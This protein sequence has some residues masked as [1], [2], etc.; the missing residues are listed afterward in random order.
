MFRVEERRKEERGPQ[1]L[2]GFDPED[3]AVIALD[4]DS[5]AV[6]SEVRGHLDTD[7][8]G[9]LLLSLVMAHPLENLTY[10]HTDRE[11]EQ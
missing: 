3:L 8:A 7:H 11:K 6:D 5:V 9:D 4:T 10:T 1:K 2:T